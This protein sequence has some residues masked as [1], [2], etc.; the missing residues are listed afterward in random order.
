M[1]E[2]KKY[3]GWTNYETGVTALWLD[4]EHDTYTFWNDRAGELYG[5]VVEEQ[6][7]ETSID[8]IINQ[9]N[10]LL[11][12]ELRESIEDNTPTTTGVYADLLNASISE[13]NWYEIA[14]H[15]T[16]DL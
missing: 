9:V 6:G 1:C 8:N 10:I 4:K 13:I 3:N 7:N 5:K 12:R 2:D 14:E 11:G 16:N 15:Y